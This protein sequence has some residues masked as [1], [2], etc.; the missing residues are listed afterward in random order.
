M[1]PA[2]PGLEKITSEAVDKIEETPEKDAETVK[3]EVMTPGQELPDPVDQAGLQ[4]AL[5]YNVTAPPLTLT[6]A[7]PD[8]PATNIVAPPPILNL[9]APPQAVNLAVTQIPEAKPEEKK[10]DTPTWKQVLKPSY[11]PVKTNFN[12]RRQVL[13]S[14]IYRSEYD[15]ANRHLPLARNAQQYDHYF[16]LAVARNDLNAM[17]AM[18]A[19]G[20]RNVDLTNAEGDSMLI[21]AIRHNAIEAARLLLAR[22]ANPGIRGQN[23]WSAM[24]YARHINNEQL[25]AAINARL[26]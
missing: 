25:I 23:G 10:D 4:G 5:P 16:I 17:R 9:P 22:G 13:P 2:L 8:Q 15:P 11:E 7:P 12:F 1:P 6:N 18:L 26:T 19:N 24:D 21:V 3:K 14:T 20:R